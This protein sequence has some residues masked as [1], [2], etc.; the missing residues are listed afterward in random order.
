MIHRYTW[1]RIDERGEQR[2]IVD[3]KA[4]DEKLRKGVLNAKAVRG[5]CE[6]T[7]HYVVLT[8]IKIKGKWEY[9]KKNVV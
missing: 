9:G 2:S 1:K 4:V 5:K 6:G 8:K 3:Y 7:D